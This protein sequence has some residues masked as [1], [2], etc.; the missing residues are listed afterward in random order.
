MIL[1]CAHNFVTSSK[2]YDP[3]SKKL[4]TNIKESKDSWFFLQRNGQTRYKALM[5]RIA[6][7]IHPNYQNYPIAHSGL[8]IALGLF[9]IQDE[10]L[11]PLN[12]PDIPIP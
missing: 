7:K 9:E 1:T 4:K 10:I 3:K 11:E 6:Y 5:H 2:E 8:D 12:F